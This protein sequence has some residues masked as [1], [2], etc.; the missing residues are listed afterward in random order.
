MFRNLL[1]INKRDQS[2]IKGHV[3]FNARFTS[4]FNQQNDPILQK[5]AKVELAPASIG[6]NL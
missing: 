5:H 6:C 1:L 2:L 4:E 3:K